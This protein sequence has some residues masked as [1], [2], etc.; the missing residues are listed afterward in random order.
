MIFFGVAFL[1]RLS[2][3]APIDFGFGDGGSCVPSSVSTA[4]EVPLSVKVLLAS[5]SVLDTFSIADSF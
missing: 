2:L 4:V 1:S 3:S 5:I